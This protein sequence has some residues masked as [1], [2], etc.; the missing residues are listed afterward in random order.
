MTAMETE[1]SL[2]KLKYVQ[3]TCSGPITHADLKLDKP[4]RE[5]FNGIIRMSRKIQLDIRV[6]SNMIL[7]TKASTDYL[8]P[9]RTNHRFQVHA[10]IRGIFKR[11]EMASDK[12]RYQVTDGR[13][14]GEERQRERE[15]D[16]LIQRERER[17]SF[18][19]IIERVIY[20][21]I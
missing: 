4:M 8:V 3:I 12:V 11:W 18:P 15:I 19:F 5:R 14:A 6:C 20:Y 16:L 13:E 1:I 2:S 7:N 9:A 17:E 21:R 10:Q